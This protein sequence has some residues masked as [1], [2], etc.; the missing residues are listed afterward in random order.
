MLA[1]NVSYED[2]SDTERYRLR[3]EELASL[4][5]NITISL[6]NDR[7]K[8]DDDEYQHLTKGPFGLPGS[9]TGK[10]FPTKKMPTWGSLIPTPSYIM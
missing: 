1:R 4:R 9:V 3:Q 10:V 5:T 8:E 6:A 7:L 2:W